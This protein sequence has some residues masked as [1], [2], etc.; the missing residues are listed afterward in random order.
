MVGRADGYGGFANPEDLALRM[1][2]SL[3]AL[4]AAMAYSL[5][6]TA[7]AHALSYDVTLALGA[8]HGQVCARCIPT[9]WQLAQGR[10]TRVDARLSEVFGIPAVDGAARLMDRLRELGVDTL[11]LAYGIT[12]AET[13]IQETLNSLR[14]RNSI[15]AAV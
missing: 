10:N 2:L 15:G 6:C 13:R 7:L 3:A 4:E 8:P 11:P 1:Q 12:D 9:A 14:G 5:T